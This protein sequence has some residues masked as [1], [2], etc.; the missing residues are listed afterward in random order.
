MSYV[1]HIKHRWRRCNSI[2]PI[3]CHGRNPMIPIDIAYENP[4]TPLPTV[5]SW[6]MHGTK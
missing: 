1:I 4:S 5:A 3:A 6:E 2:F